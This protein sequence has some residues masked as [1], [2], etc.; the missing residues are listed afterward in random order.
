MSKI[1]YKI[2]ETPYLTAPEAAAYLRKSMGSLYQMIWGKRLKVYKPHNGKLYFL[3]SD[4]DDYMK[5][6]TIL[7]YGK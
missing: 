3:Q 2:M 5:Q 4:L 7:P 1:Y 6:N